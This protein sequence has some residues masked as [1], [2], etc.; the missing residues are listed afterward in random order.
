MSEDGKERTEVE[1]SGV[2]GY[3]FERDNFGT[4]IFDVIE[5]SPA[6]IVAENE[7]LFEN[8]RSHCWPTGGDTSKADLLERFQ[9]RG[10]R[11]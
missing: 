9:K 1:S 4:I 8:G 3:D 7:D 5:K 2:E 11:G 10:T 6:R